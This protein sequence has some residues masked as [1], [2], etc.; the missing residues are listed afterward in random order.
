MT[1]GDVGLGG[2]GRS[3][4]PSSP[5]AIGGGG[6]G[7]VSGAC[8]VHATNGA[9]RCFVL[10]WPPQRCCDDLPASSHRLARRAAGRHIAP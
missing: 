2:T 5:H 6:L 10:G 1:W 3:P 4:L 8:A 9:A 7:G